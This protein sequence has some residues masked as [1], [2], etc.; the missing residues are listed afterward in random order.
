MSHDLHAIYTQSTHDRLLS[1]QLSVLVRVGDT[2]V[3]AVLGMIPPIDVYSDLDTLSAPEAL[4]TL[5]SSASDTYP[6]RI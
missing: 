4:E 1:S 6:R 2:A 3:Q 5:T